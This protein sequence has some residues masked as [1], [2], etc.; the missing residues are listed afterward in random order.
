[1][2]GNNQQTPQP[3]TVAPTQAT[4]VA[5][6]PP[7]TDIFYLNFVDSIDIDR[8][9]FVMNACSNI[10]SQIN[11]QPTTLYFLISSNG[12]DVD[13]GIALY[14]FLK[15][16]PFKIIMHNIGSIDSIANVIF[17]AGDERY[18]S[19]HTSFLFHGVALNLTQPVSFGL[20]Q[21]NEITNRL[22]I[23]QEKIA[24]IV[25]QNT[26]ITKKQIAKLFKEGKTEGTSF[27]LSKGIINAEKPAVVPTG[28]PFVSLNFVPPSK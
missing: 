26:S 19:K 21:L 15:A 18:A 28:A 5:V 17:L 8:V 23:S 14:N 20:N 24:G 27:A 12:G 3:P 7:P 10:I 6:T 25:C 11:P 2:A 13:S 9:K 22:A 16:L 4:P 1:M